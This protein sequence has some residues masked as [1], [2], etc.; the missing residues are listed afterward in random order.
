[1]QETNPKDRRAYFKAWYQKNK[2]RHKK[3]ARAY[4]HAHKQLRGKKNAAGR[5]P[6]AS[7]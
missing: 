4:Y 5:L 7:A 1:M 3:N 6:A 2:T